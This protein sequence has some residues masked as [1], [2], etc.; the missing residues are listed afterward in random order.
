MSNPKIF[1][2][3]K[4]KSQIRRT[5]IELRNKE[6]TSM[7]LSRSLGIQRSNIT[8]YLYKLAKQGRVVVV[9]EEPCQITGY[10]A[11]YYSANPADFP[12][13]KQSELF[14]TENCRV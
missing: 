10:K 11:K 4:K 5:I 7:M 3:E 9:K 13:E 1:S 6:A 12:K 14:H 2:E 8:R